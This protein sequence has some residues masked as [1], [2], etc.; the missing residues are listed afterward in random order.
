MEEQVRKYRLELERIEI[1]KSK[2]LEEE[3]KEMENRK[4]RMEQKRRN[5]KHWE[6][7]R[8]ITKFMKENQHKWKIRREN[9]MEK[10][11]WEEKK[12]AWEKLTEMEKI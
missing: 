10:K 1:R 5:E 12:D 8:W 2:R 3:K 4:I 6:M 9:E 7:L 11:R